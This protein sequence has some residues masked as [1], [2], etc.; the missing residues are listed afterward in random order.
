MRIAQLG[1]KQTTRLFYALVSVVVFFFVATADQA[2]PGLYAAGLL[3][4]LLALYPL[5]FWLLGW[6]CGLPLWPIFCL[7]TGITSAL[8]I[9]QA[10]AILGTYEPVEILTAAGT[11]GGFI[12]LGTLVW[13]A[14]TAQK[15]KAPKHIVMISR[16]HANTYL[17]LFVLS[18]VLFQL[19]QNLR[20]IEFPGNTMQIVR[21]ITM[22]LN[23][24]G[25]FVL[26][27]EHGQGLLSKKS[28]FWL[29]VLGV[30]TALGAASGLLLINAVIPLAMM[31]FGNML[32]SGRIPWKGL[33]AAIVGLA[34][35]HPGKFAMRDAVYSGQRQMSLLGLPAFYAEWIGYSFQEVGSFGRFFRATSEEGERSTLFERSGNLHMLLLV[36][37]LSPQQVP[38]MSGATYEHIP[39]MLVPRFIDDQKGISHAGNI[40]LSVN[41]GV[42]TIEGTRSTSVGWGLIPE[43]Y[44]N[45]GYL[46]VAMLAVILSGFYSLAARL[47]VDVP[48][49]S[50][51][52][53]LGLLF[54]SAATQADTMGVFVTSQFQGVASVTFAAL[55]LMRRQ[56]NPL[57]GMT[58]ANQS[59]WRAIMGAAVGTGQI[60]GNPQAAPSQTM[61]SQQRATKRLPNWMPRSHRRAFAL[62]AARREAEEQET[63]AEQT[64]KKPRQVAVPI[65][66]YYYRSRKA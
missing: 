38:Y 55:L 20:F 44:A 43:A 13:L 54:M 48:M 49:T 36:Q 32:G 37:K 61:Q 52:F 35:L 3:L 24:M 57:Y 6:S 33:A 16:H 64:V 9:V 60:E 50:L 34:V 40:I 47:T 21:G 31:L 46:G 27:F 7:V 8:P 2:D 62:A 25:L 10:P 45:F 30:A 29:I 26:S 58:G 5:Y 12:I 42:Q 4:G 19:N 39:R 22:S 14:L 28:S 41:Y 63:V 17:F 1:T 15:P 59:S 53:V 51:R 56:E 66:P 65:Q 23:T 18:G 11:I